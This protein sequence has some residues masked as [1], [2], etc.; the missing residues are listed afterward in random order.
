MQSRYTA[1]IA[2]G[3]LKLQES[4]ISASILLDEVTPTV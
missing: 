3:S 4:G 2:G 1:D